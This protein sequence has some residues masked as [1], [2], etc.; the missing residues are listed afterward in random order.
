MGS[1]GSGLFAGGFSL[2]GTDNNSSA[3]GG[4]VVADV[5][6]A[7]GIVAADGDSMSRAG[8]RDGLV[9][10]CQLTGKRDGVVVV[11]GD[12]ASRADIRDCLAEASG[13][14]VG[15]VRNRNRR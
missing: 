15:I 11:E 7:D 13:S 8:N 6:D 4:V 14:A 5:E 9:D 12:R 2:V 3:T 1:P 10:D